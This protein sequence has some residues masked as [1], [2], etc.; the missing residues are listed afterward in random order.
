MGDLAKFATTWGKIMRCFSWILV[1]PILKLINMNHWPGEYWYDT[2]ATSRGVFSIFGD[3][4][5]HF[6]VCLKD[7]GNPMTA[8]F[9]NLSRTYIRSCGSQ[10]AK[11][12]SFCYLF[13]YFYLYLCLCL[14]LYLCPYL[15]LYLC[16][17]LCPYLC[18]YLYLH[19]CLCL[20]PY[21]IL[22]YPFLSFPI[23][24]YLYCIPAL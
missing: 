15:C 22:S 21:P 11:Q 13:V 17:Y 12:I 9:F 24:S 10:I 3:Q 6:M 14:Y 16:L 4:V 7:V 1:Y 8:A 19:L 23:L 2:A 5:I 18:P 20:C